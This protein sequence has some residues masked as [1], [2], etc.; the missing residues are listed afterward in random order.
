MKGCKLTIQPDG[1]IFLEGRHPS[2]GLVLF[3]EV[4]QP[5]ELLELDIRGSFQDHK[6]VLKLK[7]LGKALITVKAGG[8][9]WVTCKVAQPSFVTLKGDLF[10]NA[11]RLNVSISRMRMSGRTA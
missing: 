1:R 3:A 11:S 7:F 2:T 6:N 9:G 10:E 8:V 4:P 5:P